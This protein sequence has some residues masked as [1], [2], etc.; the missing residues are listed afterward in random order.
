MARLDAFARSESSAS[1]MRSGERGSRRER[2]AARGVAAFLDL[3]DELTEL[4]PQGPAPL[5]QAALDSSGYLA[6]LEAER[7]VESAGRLENLGELI[8]S[9]REFADVAE[10][11]EQVASWPTRRGGR[12]RQPGHDAA[13]RQ[14]PRVP[15]GLPDRR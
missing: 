12:G 3:M 8:G 1:S 2:S 14:G 7:S 9:A 5:L 15:G 4:V 10:F 6:E 11:M 13:H